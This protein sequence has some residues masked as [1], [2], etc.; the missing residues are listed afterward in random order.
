MAKR[1]I[2]GFPCLLA[3]LE[4]AAHFP[5]QTLSWFDSDGQ[6]SASLSY[7]QLHAQVHAA[8]HSLRALT[9]RQPDVAAA[10]RRQPRQDTLG[11]RVGI[12]APTQP[13]FLRAFLACQLLGHV[14]CALPMPAPLQDFSL[15]TQTLDK[16]Q[17]AAGIG[18]LLCPRPMLA[19][20]QGQV[21]MPCLAFEDLTDPAAAAPPQS[22]L[23]LP[24]ARSDDIAC[25]QFSSGSTAQPKGIAISHGALMH[26]VDAINRHGM[27]VTED[28]RA[29]SWLP[30]YHDMGLVGLVFTPLCA[31]V[32]V[33]YLAPASFARQPFL[34]PL[35]L[36]R[37]ASTITYAPGFAWQLAAQHAAR[38][39]DLHTLRL[40]KL[41]I[42]GVGGERASFALLQA[43][44]ERFAPHGFDPDAFKPSYGLS[45]ATLAVSMSRA[46]FARVQQHY[47]IDASGHA[48]PCAATASGAQALV[49]CGVAL[50]GWQLR[51]QGSD[52]QSLPANHEGELM[53]RG[54][55]L[56]AGTFADGALQR[57]P[58]DTELATGDMGFL[59]PDG[60][61]FITGRK[62][63]MIT[64]NGR[65]IWPQDIETAL[66]ARTGMAE[67]HLLFF[68]NTARAA[69]QGAALIVL[70]H[71]NALRQCRQ[72]DALAR[73]AAIATAMTGA[74]VQALVVPDGAIARTDSGKKARGPVCAAFAEGKIKP[75]ALTHPNPAAT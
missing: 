44:A 35:L 5:Q 51:I 63:E 37:C 57:R 47:Q 65:N 75:V 2:G 38:R 30:Y 19:L 11:A 17:R 36:G 73:A 45:E 18:L 33:D 39:D 21:S 10:L 8:A 15:Y 22:A 32:S 4:Y 55:A 25:V 43:F 64:V 24:P 48:R 53:I 20:L 60:V 74:A 28:D 9:Q 40:D 61:L 42:A 7:T 27:R 16:M 29:F 13:D 58:P 62:K 56:L 54:P 70:V 6:C 50:P 26:N 72:P 3:A 41:R 59:T 46:P 12:L 66:A 71:E 1:R 23:P 67:E 14:P 49:E 69:R 34:W 31:Q 52:G 68:Q